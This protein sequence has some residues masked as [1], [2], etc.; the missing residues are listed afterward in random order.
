MKKTGILIAVILSV[1]SCRFKNDLDYPIVKGNIL[2]LRVEGQ[3]DLKIDPST[4]EAVVYLDETADMGS[5]RLVSIQYSEEATPVE[6]L[7]SV[8]DLRSPIT[9][10]LR[11]YQD[12]EW[13]ISA[14]QQISRYIVCDNQMEE[15]RFN[16]SE[17]MAYVYVADSQPLSSVVFRDMKLEPEGSEI[18]S[19]TGWDSDFNTVYRLPKMSISR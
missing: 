10:T 15:A 17:R 19:T 12:Y 13:T 9:I 1:V 2:D 5:L 7:P 14:V 8:L 3:I 11:T 6:P 16:P 18:V 4:R